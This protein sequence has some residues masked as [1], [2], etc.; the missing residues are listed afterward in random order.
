[1][2]LE[3]L[4][5]C[6]LCALLGPGAEAQE[7]AEL[8][9]PP[10]RSQASHSSFTNEMAV[11]QAVI[12][13]MDAGYRFN[14][15]VVQWRGKRVLV[16]DDLAISSRNVG[17]SIS[18]IATRHQVNGECILQ[19]ISTDRGIDR[20]DTVPRKDRPTWSAELDTGTIEEVLTAEQAGCHF[21]AYV[22][23][24]HH[25]RIAV[26]D[27]LSL[28]R[29]GAGEQLAFLAVRIAGRYGPNLSFTISPGDRNGPAAARR[30]AGSVSARENGIVNEV[31][32]A[33]ID[34]YCYRAYVLRW[35]G[36]RIVVSD[37]QTGPQYEVGDGI[38]F[39]IRRVP[40]LL[41][42]TVGAGLLRFGLGASQENSIGTTPSHLA[43]SADTA[44]V[45]EVLR[46]DVDGF[47]SVIYI[48]RWHGTRIAINDALANTH[49][50]TGQRI[51]VPVARDSASGLR[52]LSFTL[53]SFRGAPALPSTC[54]HRTAAC[55]QAPGAAAPSRLLS[56]EMDI[57]VG[58]HP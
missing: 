15:Y 11:V 41:P 50:S 34:G 21:I 2:R 31:L 13:A 17:E 47:L 46:T 30:P 4:A 8:A 14:A 39:E 10:T 37:Q 40:G 35:R 6:T 29:H 1:V 18:F 16:S 49:F 56:A 36:L 22:L 5:L 20:R 23:S 3:A 45:E 7:P 54:T 38:Q 26:S 28:S 58:E 27:P 53:F 57:P 43:T 19:F 25:A 52:R 24:W 12:S 9:T 33:A 42:G 44:I 55:N 48:A 51:E 32:T